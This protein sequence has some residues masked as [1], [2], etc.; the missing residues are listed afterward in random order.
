MS[1]VHVNFTIDKDVH[2]WLSGQDWPESKSALVNEFLKS[3]MMQNFSA[4]SANVEILEKEL[5]DLEKKTTDVITRKAIVEQELLKIRYH[6]QKVLAKQ[7]EKDFFEVKTKKELEWWQETIR[8]IKDNPDLIIG[9]YQYY[10]NVFKPCDYKQW[11]K[12]LEK[13]KNEEK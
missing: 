2:L 5:K 10:N 9:R 7:S 12:K 1:K 6:E 3:L 11:L 4:N 8:K 13:I